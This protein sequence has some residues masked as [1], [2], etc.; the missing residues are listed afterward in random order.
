M[1]R[2]LAASNDGLGDLL[3]APIEGVELDK[4]LGII[5][6]DGA[7]RSSLSTAREYAATSISA[8]DGFRDGEGANWLRGAVDQLFAR[9]AI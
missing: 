7:V 6:S 3:G 8:L 4:A 1:L 5:R 9:V 2:A